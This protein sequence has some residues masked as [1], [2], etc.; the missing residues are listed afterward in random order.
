MPDKALREKREE[1][2]SVKRKKGKDEGRRDKR[3]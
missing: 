3:R 2:K 1:G